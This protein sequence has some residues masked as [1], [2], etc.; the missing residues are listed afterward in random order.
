MDKNIELFKQFRGVSY[1]DKSHTYYMHNKNLISV[2]QFLSRLKPS[3]DSQFWLLYKTL[4]SMGHSVKPFFRKTG[5][6]NETIVIDNMP[7]SIED[8]MT[9]EI[10]LAMKELQSE[11]NL[12]SEIG[13]TRGTFGHNYLEHLERGIGEVPEIVLPKG[14][15][16]IQAI[17]YVRSIELVKKLCQEYV[18]S[19]Q[20]LIPIAIEF[21]VA[22]LDLGLAGTFDRL[23][24]N[25]IDEEYQIHDFKTDKKIDTKGKYDKLKLFDIPFCELTKYSIQTSLYKFIIEKNTSLKLGKSKIT[26]LNLLYEKLDYYDCQDFTSQIQDLYNG[27]DWATF[28]KP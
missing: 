17:E 27:D 24:W 8:V 23:Y 7:Y 14:L 3:F 25:E 15:T 22:D 19:N 6:S 13:T 5:I 28:V 1:Y 16:T 26:H 12:K 10:K 11:W 2:T 20:H 4:Q 9:D 21:K 18:N